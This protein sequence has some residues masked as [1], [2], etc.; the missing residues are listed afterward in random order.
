MLGMSSRKP[1]TLLRGRFTFHAGRRCQ[2]VPSFSPLQLAGSTRRHKSSHSGIIETLL[3]YLKIQAAFFV[4]YFSVSHS[5]QKL[6]S[7]SQIIDTDTL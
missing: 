4:M 5:E 6:D 1:S 2:S 7:T 3:I